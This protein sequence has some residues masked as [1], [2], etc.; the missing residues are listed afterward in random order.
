[1]VVFLSAPANFDFGFA[2]LANQTKIIR[3]I[4][5][6]L[7]TIF[8]AKTNTIQ[9]MIMH[10]H[11]HIFISLK[12]SEHESSEKRESSTIQKAR[13]ESTRSKRL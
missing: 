10:T 5:Y 13:N 9:N 4:D 7:K 2:K 3:G 6:L 11:I 1:M 8:F 12:R